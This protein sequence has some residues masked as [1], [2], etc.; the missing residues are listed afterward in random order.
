MLRG[1]FIRADGLVIPNNITKYGASVLL[2][3]AMRNTVPVFWVGLC[4]AVPSP[5]L[6]IEDLTEPTIATHGYAR[7]QITR[8]AAGWPTVGETNGEPFIESGWLTWLAVGGAF[9]AE[10]RRMFICASQ[11]A[12]TGDV[13]A[14]SAALPALV[15]IDTA[16]VEAARRFKYRVYLR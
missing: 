15:E 8:D 14:L 6:Q 7:I 4:D 2:A 16:T 10:I 3:A 11:T 9:D 13:F 1:E 5:D 12:T